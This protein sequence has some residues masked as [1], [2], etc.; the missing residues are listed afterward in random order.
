ANAACAR[1]A[2]AL[3]AATL[4]TVAP[5]DAATPVAA[6]GRTPRSSADHGHT[7]H[8]VAVG[9]DNAHTERGD[10]P[11]LTEKDAGYLHQRVAACSPALAL[12]GARGS[13]DNLGLN[14]FCLRLPPNA[15][16]GPV[17]VVVGDRCR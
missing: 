17:L 11:A 5:H 6:T 2:L 4:D 10:I 1:R 9:R 12:T 7:R 15:R 16:G 3:H 8:T 13:G 14:C